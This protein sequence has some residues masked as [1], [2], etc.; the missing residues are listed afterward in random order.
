MNWY[1]EKLRD[2]YLNVQNAESVATT[3]KENIERIIKEKV[4]QK[5][6]YGKTYRIDGK[7]WELDKIVIRIG[8]IT[9]TDINEK[10]SCDIYL[11]FY[12]KDP[13]QKQKEEIEIIKKLVK[14]NDYY[15]KKAHAILHKELGFTNTIDYFLTVDFNLIIE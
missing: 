6:D 11:H 10:T 13:A 5:H 2:A 7:V 9:F 4:R 1:I 8:Y 3:L 14:Y 12:K 15:P